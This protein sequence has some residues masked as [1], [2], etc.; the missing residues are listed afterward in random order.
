MDVHVRSAGGVL[1]HYLGLAME[2]LVE[3]PANG[4]KVTPDRPQSDYLT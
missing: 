1:T 3:L 4:S 2:K